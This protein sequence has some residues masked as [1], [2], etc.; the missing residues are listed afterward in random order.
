MIRK[1]LLAL[2]L[3]A[4]LAFGL[5]ACSKKSS[6]EPTSVSG[7]LRLPFCAEERI[8]PY[9]ETASFNRLL[10]E[11]VYESL[12]VIDESCM[13]VEQLADTY[14]LEDKTITV[15]L[16][17][18]LFSD[19]SAL[20]SKDVV[21]SFNRAKQ[22]DHYKAALKSIEAVQEKGSSVVRFTLASKNVYALNLLTFPILSQKNNR[23][24]S[25]LYALQEEDGA[26]SLAYNKNH[27]G[28][29]PHFDNIELVECA[30][31]S[32][33]QK[34][35][36]S[37]KIDYLFES[38]AEGNVRTSAIQSAKA[39]LN[40]LVF[41]GINSKKGLLKDAAFRKAIAYCINQSELCDTALEGFGI[42][43]ATP[44]D[45]KW[46]EMGSIVADSVLSN[47]KQAK[48]AFAD[49]GC[50][51][52][53]MGINLLYEE[54]PISLTILVN[55]TNNMKI[56][57]A[58]QIKT[59]LIGMGISV[60]INKM[61]LDEYNI[62]V[63]N[64]NFDLYLGE[65]KIPNDFNLDCFFAND[66]GADFGID[67]STIQKT[68]VLFKGG[69]ASLQDF[70]SAF[71]AQMPFIPI[72]YRCANVCLGAQLKTQGTI[73]ENMAFPQIREWSK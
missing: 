28:D 3:V 41:L 9:G 40:N 34:L 31:E 26:Y 61:P 25:G 38:L 22:S 1:K 69:N 4:A 67:F 7:S 29:K 21:F 60:D 51:Y 52:D 65:V 64:E 2:L 35:F 73:S 5:A 27:E 53:K 48:A 55:S 16:K 19:G 62:A 6:T 54:K 57:L 50:A 68:Y 33:A 15:T 24:G 14:I 10:S 39:K 32:S 17:S 18:A 43:T 23:I 42:A 11:L 44:F 58:E 8:D 12:F 36:N 46:S 20:T 49:A 56:A 13:P 71:C 30:D 59:Q 72:C 66:G 70:V 63:E 47:A 37:E 45:S